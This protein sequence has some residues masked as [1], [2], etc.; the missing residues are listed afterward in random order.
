MESSAGTR[1]FRFKQLYN[2]HENYSTP[3][4]SIRLTSTLTRPS[5]RPMESPCR[6]APFPLSVNLTYAK[7]PG[8]KAVDGCLIS[9]VHAGLGIPH[10]A[11]QVTPVVQ[12]KP[13]DFFIPL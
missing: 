7:F 9:M 2:N 3:N 13:K 11:V 1:W 8:K 4:A 12:G 10:K 5:L 6:V